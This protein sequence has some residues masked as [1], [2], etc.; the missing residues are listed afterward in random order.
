MIV[1]VLCI[2]ET[3]INISDITIAV[4]RNDFKCLYLF[5]ATAAT[6]IILRIYMEQHT[7]KVRKR[8]EVY[9]QLRNPQTLGVDCQ[10]RIDLPVF[11]P[12]SSGPEKSMF[13][14]ETSGE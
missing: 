14:L 7:Y 3:S 9:A 1:D 11:H 5:A 12:I 6:I 8:S 2:I 13:F 10:K 4:M